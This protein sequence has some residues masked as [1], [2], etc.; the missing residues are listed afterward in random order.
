MSYLYNMFFGEFFKKFV[1]MCDV[2]KL[3]I[4]LLPR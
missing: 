2:Y 3:F 4:T 1:Y